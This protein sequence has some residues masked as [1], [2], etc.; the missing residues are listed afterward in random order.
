MVK[1]ICNAHNIEVFEIETLNVC[2]KNINQLTNDEKHYNITSIC[3]EK[4][5]LCIC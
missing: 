1:P 4:L 5:R 2:S 3:N